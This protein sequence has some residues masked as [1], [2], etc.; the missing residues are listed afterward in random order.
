M[1]K[2]SS[3]HLLC[4]QRLIKQ[5][6]RNMRVVLIE[7][8][9]EAFDRSTLN[10]VSFSL[11]SKLN[12]LKTAHKQKWNIN[13]VYHLLK[14]NEAVAATE[15]SHRVQKSLNEAKIHAEVQLISYITLKRSRLTPRVICST[16]AACYLCNVLINTCRMYT[17]GSH[18]R[19]YTG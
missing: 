6:S 12:R 7:P 16:K 3:I 4:S 1:L 8:P 17:P 14:I 19:L 11:A 2:Q 9:S 10:K 5:S 13:Q 18:G 15:F